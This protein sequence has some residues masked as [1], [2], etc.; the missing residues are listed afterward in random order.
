MEMVLEIIKTDLSLVEIH[1]PLSSHLPTFA[2]NDEYIGLLLMLQKEKGKADKQDKV[3][4]KN[5]NKRL[6]I[7]EATLT[8][9]EIIYNNRIAYANVKP[10]K[11]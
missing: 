1:H 7:I 8:P 3:K 5:L 2:P 11:L 9:E 4:V 6:S 10:T